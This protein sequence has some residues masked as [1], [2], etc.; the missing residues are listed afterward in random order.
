MKK[1]ENSQRLCPASEVAESAMDVLRA[2]EGKKKEK[3][4]EDDEPESGREKIVC[5]Q[6]LILQRTSA[7][8]KLL[9]HCREVLLMKQDSVIL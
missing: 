2:D 8:G 3:T 5:K 4:A 9:V 7:T 6:I 1:L